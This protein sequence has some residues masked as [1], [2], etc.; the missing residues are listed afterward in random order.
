VA[1]VGN[2]VTATVS[3]IQSAGAKPVYVEINPETMLMD[4]AAL[5]QALESDSQ[6]KAIV[7]VHLYGRC[8]EMSE[9]VKIANKYGVKIVEDCAQAH[10]STIN[11]RIAGTFGD[12]AAFSFYPTKN[13]GALGDAGAVV[14]A[15]TETLEKV[16]LLRQYGWRQRYLSDLHGR[17]SRLDEIQA[18]ILRV[19]LN[20]LKH[21]NA[22]RSEIASTYISELSNAAP[23]LKLPKPP[24]NGTHTWHQ[25]VVRTTK[26]NELKSHLEKSEVSC[27]I[28]Y[29]VPVYQQNAYKDTAPPNLPETEKA[30]REVLSLPL[31]AGISDESIDYIIKIIRTWQR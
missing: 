12:V 3:A 9:I 4:P 25:F 29:P 10:G 17:N 6:I 14:S 21:E 19:R 7:P 31:H 26:R 18:A 5:E 24:T 20:R 16:K 13:L 22:R 23:F 30:C 2:T 28:L 15:N 11:D 8:C 1:T 27:G